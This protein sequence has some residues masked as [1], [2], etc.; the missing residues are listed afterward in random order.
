MR[1]LEALIGLVLAATIL[2]AAARRVGAPYPVFLALGGALLAFVPGAPSFTVLPELALALFV[3]PV[4]LDAAYDA[5]PRDLKD[6][7]AP[8]TGLVVFAVG[9]TTIAVAIVARTLMPEMVWAP[10]IALGAVVA[11]PDAAAATAVLRSL[12]PPRRIL[13]VLEGESLLNDASALL[14]YRLAVGAVAANGFS[15]AAVG[16][17]FLFAVAG[18]MVAGPVL[19]WLFLRLTDR[20]EDVPTAIIL[21]FVGTFG[22]WIM[23]DRIGLSG[24]LTMVCYAITVARTAPERTP[25]RIRIP[26]YAVWETVVFMLNVLAFIF[27][28][29][30]IRPI[31]E[32]L[33]PGGRGRYVAVASAVLLT[34][35]VV[36]LAWH[37][38][39]NAII[40]WR[41]RRFGFHPP[42]PMLR[43][44]VGSGLV[45]SW[46][47]M[48][49]IVSLAA[50]LA[51]PAAFPFRDLIVLTAF[52][53]VVGT[54]VLQGLTL[55][56]LL[57]VLDL[58]DDDPVGHEVDAARER[59]LGAVLA[60]FEYDRSPVAEAVRQEFIAHLGSRHENEA[61]QFTHSDVHRRALHAAR[62]AVLAMRASDEIGDDAFH[63]MEE[64]L[65]WIEMAGSGKEDADA[66][67]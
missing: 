54:L 7:W 46:A 22:V 58:R 64:E 36:R 12:K 14:I 32:S 35:I 17:T 13:T 33:T 57:R 53:V 65:D 59:A 60:R 27:I 66:N 15:I 43:P 62:Q 4:L 52:F 8:L 28:G 42:R 21:Q 63:Q 48:R 1:Q 6:N 5:S 9:L 24:V 2:A 25:A 19:G 61:P 41:E 3:A 16:P 18:S 11:P 34:V 49:G 55:G 47:G 67:G 23:A 50:A 30:Q 40:R 10:A 39:F 38:S 51:L 56:P 29:L 26:S 45:I 44:S 31:F 20:V 37:M